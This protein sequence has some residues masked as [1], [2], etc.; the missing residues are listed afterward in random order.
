[1]R[2][3]NARTLCIITLVLGLLALSCSLL[4]QTPIWPQYHYD[5]HR[6]GQNSNSIDIKDPGLLN[7][8]WVFPRLDSDNEYPD[9]VD[10]IVDDTDGSRGFEAR[11]RWKTAA[12]LLAVFHLPRASNPREPSVSSTIVSTCVGILIVA[13]QNTEKCRVRFA[14]SGVFDVDRVGVLS[15]AVGVISGTEGHGRLCQRE[16]DDENKPGRE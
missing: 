10:T 8:I 11:G 13:I 1:M 12:A 7:L 9:E 4:A 2:D 6:T 16:Q 5:A 14:Q 3:M 15:G